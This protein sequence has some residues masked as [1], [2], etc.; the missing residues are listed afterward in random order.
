MIQTV[1]Y[2]KNIIMKYKIKSEI[3]VWN[4]LN[5]KERFIR[6]QN[7]LTDV[8]NSLKLCEF[9]NRRESFEIIMNCR[10][11]SCSI[12]FLKDSRATGQY[13]KQV[14]SKEGKER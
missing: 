11:M 4:F 2:F 6:W 14:D 12:L 10:T 9:S 7:I 3:R 13:W 5:G 1:C 8:N